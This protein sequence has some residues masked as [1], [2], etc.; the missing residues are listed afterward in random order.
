MSAKVNPALLGLLN[1]AEKKGLIEACDRTYCRNRL[2]QM[3]QLDA[4][5]EGEEAL[6][7]PLAELLG[8]LTDSAVE[9]GLI[10]DGVVT[11][12]LLDSLLMEAVTPFPHEV[13]RTFAGKYKESA[14]AATDWFY[15]FSCDTNYIRRDRIARDKKW[16]YN[17]PYG[18]LDITI[19]LSK[20]EKDPRA[21][22]AAKLLPQTDYPKCQLCAENEGYAGRLNH[23]G[24]SN[25]V[26][27][28]F[29][30]CLLQ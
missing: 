8:I 22:A 18:A 3:L 14:L 2:L 16:V 23:P 26:L 10:A 12:D 17:G 29:A 24:R 7:A 4:P 9:R 28:V 13:R 5:D 1:Y 15:A 30:V 27:P 11:R 6:D 21:I 19:N 25:L 20:P